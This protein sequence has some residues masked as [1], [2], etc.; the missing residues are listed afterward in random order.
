MTMGN[1]KV[2]VVLVTYNSS[3][4][5]HHSLTP[6]ANCEQIEI[7]IIDN[8]SSDDTVHIIGKSFPG[9]TLIENTNNDGFAKAV[10]LAAQRA[11][12]QVLVLLN[13]DAIIQP[14]DVLSL[15]DRV[16]ASD[17]LGIAAPLI[18]HPTGDLRIVSGG[19]FPTIWRMFCHYFGLSRIHASPLFEGHYF[20][21]SEV[22]AS[23]MQAE[24][25]TGAC[26]AMRRDLWEHLGGLSERWFMYAEDIELC[27]RV[28]QAGLKTVIFPDVPATHLVGE[29]DSTSRKSAN[30]V[31]VLNLF[32]FYKMALSKS[33]FHNL[34]WALVVGVGL[35]S[36]S[37]VYKVHSLRSK[38]EVKAALS[39][40]SYRFRKFATA[41]IAA[42]LSP[43]R[44]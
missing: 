28:S 24:W 42:G 2:S 27:Y 10:N 6:L 37:I 36:R 41:T 40:E 35:G 7:L 38:R 30:P 1:A 23:P 29:S 21:M 8:N 11:T 44:G 4:V 15:A 14:H 32:D 9:I 19:R 31:W 20:L 17:G 12:G 25:A 13:P 22:E 5:I 33:K 26:L 16:I 34:T 3:S 39:H 43:D 18:K